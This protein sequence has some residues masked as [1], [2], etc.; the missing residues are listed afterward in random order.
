MEDQTIA[1][2]YLDRRAPHTETPRVVFEL[3]I[4]VFKRCKTIPAPES[5][6]TRVGLFSSIK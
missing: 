6:A 2:F 3:T 4:P 5:A 1:S